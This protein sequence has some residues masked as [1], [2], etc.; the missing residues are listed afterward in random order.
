MFPQPIFHFSSLI[1]PFIFCIKGI[2]F[3][4]AF[5]KILHTFHASSTP[6]P[7]CF[8]QILLRL[9]T[10]TFQLIFIF[11]QYT[12]LVLPKTHVRQENYQLKL[13]ILQW[14]IWL[15]Q[16][17]FISIISNLPYMFPN[18]FSRSGYLHAYGHDNY[19]SRVSTYSKTNYKMKR[20]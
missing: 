4:E 14:N 12:C 19:V 1:P 5:L 3:L 8:A 15:T 2:S 16:S 7:L 9:Y 13:M 17:S 6:K 18:I 20:K 11:G 10:D